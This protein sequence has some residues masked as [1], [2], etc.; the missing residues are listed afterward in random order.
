MH[1]SSAELQ[2]KKRCDFRENVER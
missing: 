1:N 2:D